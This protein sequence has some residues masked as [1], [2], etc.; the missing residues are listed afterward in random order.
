MH[1]HVVEAEAKK[2][3]YCDYCYNAFVTI[4]V[5]YFTGMQI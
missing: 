4:T 2:S 3:Q 5:K 1:L